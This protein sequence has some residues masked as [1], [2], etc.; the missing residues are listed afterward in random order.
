MFIIGGLGALQALGL[1]LK[2]KSSTQDG[3]SLNEPTVF[4]GKHL[5]SLS[6]ISS[7]GPLIP[8]ILLLL[9]LALNIL[10]IM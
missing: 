8:G 6:S 4:F 5:D 1:V 7:D 2:V 10:N 3:D 9:T